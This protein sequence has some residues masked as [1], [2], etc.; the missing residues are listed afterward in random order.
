MKNLGKMLKWTYVAAAVAM[1]AI[2][3]FIVIPHI[4]LHRLDV[5]V[6]RTEYPVK[7]IDI[8][9]HNGDVDFK[10]VKGDSVSFVIIKATDGVGDYDPRLSDNYKGAR[11]NGLDVG[12]YHYFRF[13]R[14]GHQQADYLINILKE[15]NMTLDLPIAIDI[16]RKFNSIDEISAMRKRLRDMVSD[17]HI[18]GYRTMIYSNLND[19]EEFIRNGFDDVDLWIASSREPADTVSQRRLWQHSHYGRVRGIEGN[20]DINTFNGSVDQYRQWVSL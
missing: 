18:A 14:D 5:A 19:Y 10:A 7:G 13:H 4:K 6:D 12:V 8:S 16:E 2:V 20:V 11:S 1:A 15:M 3:V 17:L 9:H